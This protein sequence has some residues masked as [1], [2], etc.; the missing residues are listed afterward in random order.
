MTSV[1]VDNDWLV[2][3]S[4]GSPFLL[5][6]LARGAGK[7]EHAGLRG[8]SLDAVLMRRVRM[9]PVALRRTLEV[10]AVAGR[11]LPA[12]LTLRVSRTLLCADETPPDSGTLRQLKTERLITTSVGV[13]TEQE[14]AIECY[15]DRIRESVTASL[16]EQVRREVHLRLAEH[17]ESAGADPEQLSEH[18]A[19][20]GDQ[21]KAATHA[22]T[23]ADAAAASLAFDLA[24][25]LYRRCL[26][27]A[28]FPPEEEHVIGLAL[29]EALER[30]GR[31]R[32]SGDRYVE[33]ARATL[34]GPI[35]ARSN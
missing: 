18:Y 33:L 13:A 29:A 15:H 7:A 21:K 28:Y 17:L 5:T 3:E 27:Q 31:G 22:R 30:A 12:G 6:E 8:A 14:E 9:L 32:E 4:G 20:G 2:E 16:A 24:A 10:V 35:D 1:Q 34:R 11:P 25:S 23:A 19:E 26:A